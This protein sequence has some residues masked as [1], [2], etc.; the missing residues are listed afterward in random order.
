LKLDPADT[1]DI[2]HRFSFGGGPVR[3]QWVRLESVLEILN[4]NQQY[5]TNV[6]TLLGEMLAAVALVADGIKFEGAVA[7]QSKGPGP[8][9]TVLAECR[10]RHLLRGIARWPESQSLPQS[11]SMT[12][13]LGQGQLALTLIPD[14]SDQPYQG[15][16]GI[17][18]S[19]LAG[20]LEQY[21]AVSEQLQ[22]RLMFATTPAT[23]TGLLLQR[24]PDADDATEIELDQNDAFWEEIGLM[25]A[26]LTHRELAELD[27][28]VLLTRLYSEHALTLQPPRTLKFSCTCNRDKTSA[29]LKSLGREDLMALLDEQS[30]ILVTC[31]ICG[32]CHRFDAFDVHLLYEPES[33]RVH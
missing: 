31:E 3:G 6:G 26:T 9:T 28:R 32:E 11:A 7:L 25:M 30:E 4:G 17:T 5:P 14:N 24:L 15:L 23:V 22:T 10:S 21:F 27:P 29:T 13:L 16:V 18:D 8:L 20:N 12:D 19:G 33:P 1:S 2:I